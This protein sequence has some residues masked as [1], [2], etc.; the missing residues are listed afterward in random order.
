M[1]SCQVGSIF[2]CGFF[3]NT[4]WGEGVEYCI[5]HGPLTLFRMGF[6]NF[7]G[8]LIGMCYYNET[9]HK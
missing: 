8:I 7:S 5:C 3:Y 1:G 9:L 6:F 2:P 4:E